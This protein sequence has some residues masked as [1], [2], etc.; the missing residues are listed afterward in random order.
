MFHSAVGLKMELDFYEV[1]EQCGTEYNHLC[2]STP[3]FVVGLVSLFSSFVSLK[4][5]G[6]R[7]GEIF[8]HVIVQP[9][10]R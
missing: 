5:V 2:I 7:V 1:F 9:S 10:C 4:S 8:V 6:H 3:L